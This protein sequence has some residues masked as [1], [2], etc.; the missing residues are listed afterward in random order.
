MASSILTH[1]E[2]A[3]R[4][5]ILGVTEA[6]NADPNPNKVNLG[7]GVYYDDNG[8]VPLLECVRRAERQSIEN[9]PPRSYL[10]IDGLPEYDRAVQALVFG[11][12]SPVRK[13]NRVVTVQAL[14]GTGGLKIGADLLRRIDPDAQ[15]WISQPSWENHRALFENAGF[16]VQA[17]PYYDA[18]TRG[19]DFGGMMKALSA[20]PAGTVVVLHA[21]CHN[22]TGV[23]LASEQWGEIIDTVRSRGLVPFLDLAYQGF[24]DGVEQDAEPV[25]RFAASGAPLFVSNSFS[26][27]FSLYGERVGALSVL[28]ESADEA[29]RVLSQLKR[30]VRTNYSNPPTHGGRIVA[31]VLNTPELRALWDDELKQMRERIRSMRRQLAEKIQVR[32]PGADIAFVTRQRGMF[33]YTGLSKEAVTRLREEFSVYAVDTGRICVAALNSHNLDYAAEAI[34]KVMR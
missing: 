6:F 19:L 27:S 25:R 15:V 14:G 30:M 7:V 17:Y 26:K 32:R 34:A 5:P 1:V 31:T 12:D 10:P 11:A 9:A 21:C 16:D 28:A 13:E 29:G 22:P 18:A 33:S 24:G 23:D 4:D 20:R 3:P 8:K 2:M